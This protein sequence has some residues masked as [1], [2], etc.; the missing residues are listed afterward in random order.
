MK[1]KSLF[2]TFFVVLSINCF[3][4]QF[5]R[6]P[7]HYSL[8][9]ESNG[10]IVQILLDRYI[11]KYEQYLSDNN[12]PT[13]LVITN[14]YL[15]KNI[16]TFISPIDFILT[17]NS[18]KNIDLSAT[19]DSLIIATTDQQIEFNLLVSKPEYP[20]RLLKK[21]TLKSIILSP[22]DMNSFLSSKEQQLKAMS[23]TTTLV[24]IDQA[25]Q[26]A[27]LKVSSDDDFLTEIERIEKLANEKNLLSG[28][29]L[30]TI[31]NVDISLSL[32]ISK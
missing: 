32:H 13:S 20:K 11:P 21:G 22:I 25:L 5:T 23:I 1:R 15:S 19:I 26:S 7:L 12:D 28:G 16:S 10:L 31:P 30:I 6:V 18:D 8:V 14:D 9:G 2:I 4:Q 3:S 29:Y 24:Y 17:N 27:K